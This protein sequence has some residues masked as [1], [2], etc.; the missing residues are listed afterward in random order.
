MQQQCRVTRMLQ[1]S[2]LWYNEQSQP[3]CIKQ[4]LLE[5][6]FLIWGHRSNLI[7]LAQ[8]FLKSLSNFHQKLFQINQLLDAFLGVF[9]ASNSLHDLRGQK[10]Y[11]HV[12]TWW[13]ILNKVIEIKNSVECMVWLWCCLFQHGIPVKIMIRLMCLFKTGAFHVK[14]VPKGQ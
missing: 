5:G 7:R 2:D 12:K 11:A 10:N 3:E 14:E 8:V 4:G 6:I 1:Y 9:W 13:R